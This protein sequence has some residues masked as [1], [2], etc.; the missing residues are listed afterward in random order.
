MSYG[1]LIDDAG[2]CWPEIHPGLSRAL[3]TD[4]TGEALSSF[5]V[6]NLGFVRL[7]P[8]PSSVVIQLNP[9]TVAAEAVTG[10][11]YWFAEARLERAVLEPIASTDPIQMLTSRG[12]VV[13][14]LGALMDARTS[15]PEFI[16]V[17]L[18]TANSQLGG[19]LRIAKDIMEARL[20]VALKA[21]LLARMFDERITVSEFDVTD[22]AF[23]VVA[24]GKNI[25][26]ILPDAET[27]LRGQSFRAALGGSYGAWVS[28]VVDAAGRTGEPVNEAVEAVVQF[29][30]QRPRRIFYER[31]LVPNG[32]SAAVSMSLSRAR[33]TSSG[34]CQLLTVTTAA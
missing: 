24:I 3:K 11:Y 17:R 31:L 29:G 6:R 21:D 27:R 25:S 7:L 4:R 23:K 34:P 19:R 8:R 26:R 32:A 20:P 9:R 13:G 14:Y 30:N 15:R 10:A 22:N 18:S 28:E 1:L 33:G 2:Q 5:A 12:D 16:A